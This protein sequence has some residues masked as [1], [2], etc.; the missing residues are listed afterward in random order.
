MYNVI[1]KQ[2]CGEFLFKNNSLNLFLLFGIYN[3][4]KRES[5]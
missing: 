2:W 1:K 4:L 5:F 3:E